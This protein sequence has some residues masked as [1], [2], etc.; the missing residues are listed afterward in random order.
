VFSHCMLNHVGSHPTPITS[1]YCREF[2][3]WHLWIPRSFFSSAEFNVIS[4]NAPFEQSSNGCPATF[5]GS[6]CQW[7]SLAVCISAT[8]FL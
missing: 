3:S 1:F 6:G 5:P 7:Y 2:Y 8:A 4:P